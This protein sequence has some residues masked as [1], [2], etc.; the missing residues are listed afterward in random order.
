MPFHVATCGYSWL[1]SSN[2]ASSLQKN[3]CIKLYNYSTVPHSSSLNSVPLPLYSPSLLPPPSY[4]LS[5]SSS[6]PPF[7]LS[8][9]SSLSSLPTS[10]LL[11][12]SSHPISPTSV[13]GGCREEHSTK[14]LWTK[15][16]TL[17]S[18]HT[19]YIFNTDIST[20]HQLS[21]PLHVTI[22]PG[23]SFTSNKGYLHLYV[24]P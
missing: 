17:R 18:E 11:P 19:I 8:P 5:F 1:T 7:H 23:L 3:A 22:L 12:H 2:F 20:Q 15:Q 13:R 24:L 16:S 21:T 9:P 4:L 14:T 6:P 10:S